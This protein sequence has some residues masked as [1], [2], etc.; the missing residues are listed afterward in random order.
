MK[1]VSVEDK[2]TTL[3]TF[4]DWQTARAE[5]Q[6]A[7]NSVPSEINTNSPKQLHSQLGYLASKEE[8]IAAR[9]TLMLEIAS[10]DDTFLPITHRLGL[11][12]AFDAT[13][14]PPT[15]K[16]HKDGSMT[17]KSFN[18]NS[19]RLD[20]NEQQ[21]NP[22]SNPVKLASQAGEELERIRVLLDTRKNVPVVMVWNQRFDPPRMD[23]DEVVLGDLPNPR[24]SFQLEVPKV[25]E[26]DGRKVV[27]YA[28]PS[29]L[30]GVKK[31]RIVR[32]DEYVQPEDK[33]RN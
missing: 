16:L 6:R 15:T 7:Y 20:M 22:S 21:L 33:Y 25:N 26:I 8:Q 17:M 18:F 19:F 3:D 31:G 11:L 23:Y 1:S 32:S 13:N 9:Q 29:R 10:Q 2:I 4:H 14:Q 24:E 30:H 28:I 27:E 12:A 5:E